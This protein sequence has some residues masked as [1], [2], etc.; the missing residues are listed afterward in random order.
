V[1]LNKPI[2]T[3]APLGPAA[4]SAP[5]LPYSRRKAKW[6]RWSGLNCTNNWNVKLK[7]IWYYIWCLQGFTH[8]GSSSTSR[9]RVTSLTTGSL[10]SLCTSRSLRTNL[11]LEK[12]KSKSEMGQHYT[13]VERHGAS[14]FS[15]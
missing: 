7:K 11:S 10:G 5:L 3:G 9:S 4:P 12:A 8:S 1:H 13:L 6:T 2:L 15:V 14:Q